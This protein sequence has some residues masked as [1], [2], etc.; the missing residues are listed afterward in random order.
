VTEFPAGFF[1]RADE[2][3]DREFYS[4]DRLVTHLDQD[5]IDAVS[6]LY[7]ELA[8]DGDVLDICSSWISHFDPAPA[9]LV[10]LGMNTNELAANKEATD[11]LVH[12][13]NSDPTVPFDDASFD[14]VTCCA[15]VDYLTRPVEVFGDVAR[16]LRPGGVFVVTF[17]NRCFPTKAIR[18]WLGADDRQRCSIVAAYF[19]FVDRFGPASVQLRNPGSAGDPLYAVWART[20]PAG[21]RIRAATPDD[22]SFITDMQYEALFVPPGAC[23]FP[24]SIVDE[25]DLARYH[26]G[27]GSVASDVGRIAVGADGEPI[28]AAWARQ[29]AGYGFVDA[30]TPE[31]GIAVVPDRRGS[32]VGGALLESLLDAVPR[33]S[34]SV[35]RRNPAIRLY[36]RVGF[37]VVRADGD[38]IVMLADRTER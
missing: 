32:G 23:P 3:P 37:E 15:S 38:S 20:F 25:P 9:R 27:F 21:I 18:A 28:G 22:G 33:L 12:D 4:V 24:R 8:L 14:A 26:A 31:L 2:A 1:A 7:R 19:A 16:V 11:T 13:L 17:S 35:D 29:V 36:E 5:A 34:L 10:A 30:E 6:G